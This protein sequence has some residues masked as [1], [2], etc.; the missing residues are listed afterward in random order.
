MEP[1]GSRN[2][3][4]DRDIDSDPR[5]TAAREE[6]KIYK[7]ISRVHRACNAC[8]KQKAR[9]DGPENPPAEDAGRSVS[10]ASLK[11]RQRTLPP[12]LLLPMR[13]QAQIASESWK[14]K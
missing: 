10:N 9:C 5:N 4:V 11:S 1:S 12:L 14:R 7:T 13:A 6:V 8:R 2:D 3:N